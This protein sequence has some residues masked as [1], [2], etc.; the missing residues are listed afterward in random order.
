MSVCVYV[1]MY[2]CICVRVYL[3]TCCIYV[4]TFIDVL[5]SR[6]GCIH[7]SIFETYTGNAF[8]FANI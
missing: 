7:L 4:C 1:C 3:F 5:Y 6:Y 2:N 8:M